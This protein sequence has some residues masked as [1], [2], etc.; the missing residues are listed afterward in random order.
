MSNASS[1]LTDADLY[2]QMVARLNP[3]DSRAFAR[4]KH[5]RIITAAPGRTLVVYRMAERRPT[6]LTRVS[7]VDLASDEYGMNME[8]IDLQTNEKVMVGHAPQ[9]LFLYPMFLSL[10]A[11]CEARYR[12]RPGDVDKPGLFTWPVYI[13]TESR[14]HLREVGVTYCETAKVFSAEFDATAAE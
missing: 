4:T 9:R 10:P 8:M 6:V 7:I 14:R 12:V 13:R 5:A 2:D 1:F 3:A 11:H